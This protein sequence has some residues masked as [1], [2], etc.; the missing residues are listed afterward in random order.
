MN[1]VKKIAVAGATITLAM[2]TYVVPVFAAAEGS[3]ENITNDSFADSKAYDDDKVKVDVKNEDTDFFNF[4]SALATSGLNEQSYND[5]GND[6][7]TE[8]GE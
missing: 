3:N 1:L 4:D 2:G 5:D 8:T 6:L 7:S